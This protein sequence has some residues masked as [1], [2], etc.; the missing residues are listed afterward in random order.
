MKFWRYLG[1]RLLT[2]ILV[3]WI[4]V[5][6]VFFVPRFFPSDPVEAMISGLTARSGSLQPE[7]VEAMRK[8]MRQDFGL[9]G[10]LFEQ[11]F[12]FI[13]RA[14]FQL[15]FGVSLSNFPTPVTTLIFRSLPYTLGLLTFST[16]LSWII[17]NFIGLLA[18]FRKDKM[19][20]K[21]LEAVA[22]VL[23]P[24]PYYIVA[25][26]LLIF[27]CFIYKFF[28]LSAVIPIPQLSF[29]YLAKLLRI[30]FLPALSIVLIGTGWWIISMK[31]LSSSVAEEDFVRYAR[32]KGVPEGRIATKYVLKNSILTQ[33]TALALSLG[34]VFNGAIMVEIMFGYPGV[35]TLVQNGI[36]QADYNLILGTIT[37]SIIAI[38]TATLI[39]DLVYPFID[40]RIR[41]S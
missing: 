7:Q 5:T 34:G 17:G 24:I 40:P 15:D 26:V 16:V 39:A 10:T 8:Q 1:Q 22:I 29:D 12:S 25:L 21:I 35:G 19:Y 36:L 41:Y 3:I 37:L 18:G 20:S 6:F 28:P 38:S 14:V 2:Y 13:K 4:G 33:I 30:S 31:A 23:Y 32:F 9:E 11:Y 27:F